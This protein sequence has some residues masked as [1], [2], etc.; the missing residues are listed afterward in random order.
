MKIKNND[1]VFDDVKLLSLRVIKCRIEDGV[2]SYTITSTQFG[3]NA[4]QKNIYVILSYFLL[5]NNMYSFVENIF[6]N[7]YYSISNATVCRNVILNDDT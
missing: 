1:H 6:R 4:A 2:K 3:D 5:Y 7:L